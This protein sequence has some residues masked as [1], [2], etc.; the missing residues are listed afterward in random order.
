[1]SLSVTSPITTMLAISFA[2]FA[3]L[4]ADNHICIE[5]ARNFSYPIG[6]PHVGGG[7]GKVF[8][9]KLF[10]VWN[11]NSGAIQVVNR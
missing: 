1:M 6:T 10:N 4:V 3:M 2:R 5:I 9:F 7:K 8:K 11:E